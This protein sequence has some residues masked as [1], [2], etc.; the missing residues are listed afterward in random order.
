MQYRALRNWVYSV[1]FATSLALTEGC[2]TLGK[3][4]LDISAEDKKPVPTDKAPSPAPEDQIDPKYKPY[5]DEVVNT[6]KNLQTKLETQ[7]RGLEVYARDR[8]DVDAGRRMRRTTDYAKTRLGEADAANAQDDIDTIGVIDG[9][10][11]K[12]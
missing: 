12:N 5:V 7:R 4:P 9:R 10:I 1:A 11:P 3:A 6:I 8:F 2:S